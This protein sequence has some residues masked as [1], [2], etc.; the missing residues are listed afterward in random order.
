MPSRTQNVT[1]QAATATITAPNFGDL[2]LVFAHRDG[3]TVAP[4]LV[5][6]YNNIATSGAN[7]NSVRIAYKISDGTETS[8]GTWTNATSV[9]VAVY[10]DF[11]PQVPIGAFLVGT[12][13]SATMS[14]NGLTMQVTDGTSWVV[15]FGAHRTATDVGTNAPSGMTVRSSTTDIAI[16]DTGAGVSS[17]STATAG[18]NASSGWTTYTI[19]LVA[20]ATTTVSQ[21]VWHGCSQSNANFETGNSFKIPCVNKTIAGNSLALCLTYAQSVGRTVSI[22]DDASNSW[23]AA[24]LKVDDSSGDLTQAIYVLPNVAANTSLIT[25]V[26][27]TAIFSV[28]WDITEL[29][30]I[31][32]TSPVDDTTSNRASTPD[33]S[34]GTGIIT[35]QA[36]D[37][38]LTYG[39]MVGWGTA[40]VGATLAGWRAQSG[41]S[42]LSGDRWI[43]TVCQVGIRAAT[44]AFT[45]HVYTACVGS[46][47]PESVSMLSVALKTDNTKGAQSTVVPRVVNVMKVR[48]NNA[49]YPPVT[50]PTMGNL[51]VIAGSSTP[52]QTSIDAVKDSSN[53]GTAWTRLVP[54]GFPQFAYIPNSTPDATNVVYISNSTDGLLHAVLYD[55]AGA[56]TSP[57]DN[58]QTFVRGSSLTGPANI[59]NAPSITTAQDNELII[60]SLNLFTGP[61]DTASAPTG[62]IF[63]CGYYTGMTDLSPMDSG[64]GYAHAFRPTAGATSFTWHITAVTTSDAMAH[65]VA[66]KAAAASGTTL[67]PAQAALTLAALGEILKFS[68]N[69][70]DEP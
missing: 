35:T 44:G 60:A 32:Q 48:V 10:R 4:T 9:A 62:I 33:L 6:G 40:M 42:L 7:T 37:L 34:A 54:A 17:W 15:G 43:G 22:T 46:S 23:P 1:A 65:A 47:G 11:D 28:Q 14:Y 12:G 51:Q 16:F 67:T 50:F 26:F 19:E 63:D 30:G 64:D 24:A 29:W 2:I 36:N 13:A 3:S 59:A 25:V 21:V 70:P 20:K 27:D 8:I 69:L 45:P 58:D 68:I 61:P 38:I 39:M 53:G 31:A 5:S 56:A 57:Y 49:T 52:S 18:V 41:Y 66:F 55:I